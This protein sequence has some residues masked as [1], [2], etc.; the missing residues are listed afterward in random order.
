MAPLSDHSHILP[1]YDLGEEEG[2]PYMVLPLMA[3][4]T[5]SFD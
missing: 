2:Q 5:S 4:G 1:I 3:S